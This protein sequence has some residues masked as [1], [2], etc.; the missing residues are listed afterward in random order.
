MDNGP[1]LIERAAALLRDSGSPVES[2]PIEA[3]SFE[4]ASPAASERLR[5]LARTCILDRAALAEAGVIMPWLTT[6]RVVEE[7]RIVKGHLIANWKSL[8]SSPSRG[9]PRAVMVTSAK[10]REGKSFSSINL[11]LAFAAEEQLTVILIDADP[12][13]GGI[14]K[15]LK[16]PPA[17][18]L[19]TVLSG[20]ASLSDALTQTDVP[21]L[22]VLPSGEPGP[23]I[24][25]LLTG[26]G[27]SRVFA[28][29]ARRY[30]EHVMILDTPPA[31]ASTT[32]AGL[33]PLVAQIV[34][35]LEAGHTQ[36]PEVEAA[37][38]LLSGCEHISFLLNKAT[39]SSGHFGSYPY[40]GLPEDTSVQVAT[41]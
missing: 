2:R 40:Y 37:L 6:S 39:P 12:V 10:P 19:T 16:V 20:E 27:A 22:L 1:T 25:E 34:F 21:N 13:R 11:A 30:P 14:G 24:P 33:A 23:H 32:P 38:R 5:P 41:D 26:G 18:G 15:Y 28:E 36:H 35:V 3:R 8:S 17:P 29:L 31:L 9:S 7:F 4:T